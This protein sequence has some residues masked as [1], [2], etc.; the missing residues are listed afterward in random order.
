[1][2]LIRKRSEKR[3]M[4]YRQIWV[5]REENSPSLQA[6]PDEDLS[7]SL[8]GLMSDLEQCRVGGFLP[9]NKWRVRFEGDIM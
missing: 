6:P 2:N 1:M 4:K 8:P 9:L 5:W 3:K 7:P